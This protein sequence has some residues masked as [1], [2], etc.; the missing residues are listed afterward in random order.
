MICVAHN[1]A[2]RPSEIVHHVAYA[3]GGVSG[4]QLLCDAPWVVANST[5]RARVM[6]EVDSLGRSMTIDLTADPVDCM[7]CLVWHGRP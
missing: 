2:P 4:F 1:A 6:T 7:K 5:Y 3:S